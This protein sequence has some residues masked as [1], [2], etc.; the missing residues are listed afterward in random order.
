MGSFIEIND[1]LQITKEQGFPEEL[2]I[3]FH[4]KTPYT[5]DQFINKIF[6]FHNKPDI[7]VYKTPP[8]R[9]FLLKI[10]MVNG[11]IGDLFIL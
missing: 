8:T 6:T 4:I 11:F 3:D 9:N 1:T 10:K 2:D 5:A 7:R